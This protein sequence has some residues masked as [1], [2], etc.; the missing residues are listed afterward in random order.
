MATE[1]ARGLKKTDS[2]INVSMVI[3]FLFCNNVYLL[4]L[5]GAYAS[6]LVSEPW[7]HTDD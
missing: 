4:A 7:C 3:I 5:K 1:S 2:H 6:S